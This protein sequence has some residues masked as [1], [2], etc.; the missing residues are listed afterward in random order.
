MRR[1]HKKYILLLIVVGLSLWFLSP[2]LPK[3]A[4]DVLKIAPE[5]VNSCYIL[6]DGTSGIATELNN[7]DLSSLLMMLQKTSLRFDGAD[8]RISVSPN[9]V[10][11]VLYLQKND[12]TTVRAVISSEGYFFFSNFKYLISNK[13]SDLLIKFF[14]NRILSRGY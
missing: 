4:L 5:E 6:I 3:N 11:C 14:S 7:E 2:L 9:T 13:N 12:G 1:T 8:P 10:K